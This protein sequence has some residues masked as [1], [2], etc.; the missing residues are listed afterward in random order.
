MFDVLNALVLGFSYGI[1]PCTISCA[2]L[3]VPLIM[4][5]SKNRRE[6]IIL[7]LIFSVGRI[8]S[9][10]LLGF[11]AGWL[12]NTINLFVSKKVLGI[13]FVVVG[14]A[15]LFKIQG[16][17]ILKSKIKITS[18]WM[19]LVT[20]FIF[21]LGPCPPLLGLLGLAVLTKSALTGA[22]M[23]LVFGI[24][25]IVSPIIILGLFSGWIAKNPEFRRV[26]PYVSGGF[27]ILMGIAYIIFG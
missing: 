20:G 6:G 3:I 9:Y 26:I 22:L 5:V 27:L 15:V 1:G 18:G 16:K 23:G 8:I 19:A 12:G 10:V 14:S 4:S 11:L 13:F 21:G 25:T 2:P 24:G 17:C 7:S